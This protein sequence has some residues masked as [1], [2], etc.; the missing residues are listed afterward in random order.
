M[1][2]EIP[3]LTVMISVEED[4]GPEPPQVAVL[5]QLPVSEAVYVT[6]NTGRVAA[7]KSAN[8]KRIINFFIL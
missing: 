4:G 3:A 1:W 6:A 7:R 8:K 2:T 5:L